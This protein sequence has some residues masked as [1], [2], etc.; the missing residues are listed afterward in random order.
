[1][2]EVKNLVK[3]YS[4]KGGVTVKALDDVSVKFPEKGMVF[5][6]GRSGSGKSTLLNVSGGLDRPDS[7]EIIVK[8]KSSRDFTASDF[9]SYRNTYIGFVFQE[10]N[11]LNEFTVEQNIALALQLQSKPCDRK[12]VEELLKKVDLEGLGKRKPNTLSGG[13]KQRVAIARALIKE[14]EIIMADEPTGALDSST[15]KQVFDTLKKLS[16]T[17]LV[18]VVSH[19]REFAEY[20]GDRIIELKDGKIISDVSKNYAAP[21][22]AGENVELISEDTITVKKAEDITEA[23]IKTIVG[24]LKAQG[25]EAVITANKNELADVKRACRI[26]DD[27]KKEYFAETKEIKTREYGAGDARFI[28]SRLPAS[29]AVK[30][31][32][33]GLK[34]KPVRLLFT[35]F[36]SVIAFTLFGVASTLMLYDSDYSV[37][38][39]LQDAGYPH[40]TINKMYTA[41]ITNYKENNFT[42]ETER[43]S[44]QVRSYGT[45]FGVSELSDKNAGGQGNYAGIFDLS[46]GNSDINTSMRLTIDG[47]NPYVKQSLSRYYCVEN[48]SGFTDCGAQYM[49][50]NGFS[51][52]TD[53]GRYPENATEVA[54]PRYLADLFINTDDNGINSY[55]DLTG[56]KLQVTGNSVLE[57]SGKNEFTVTGVYDVGD[58][59]AKYDALKEADAGNS[60]SETT[61]LATSLRDCLTLSYHTVLYV[62]ED[63]Y[64]VY[65]DGIDVTANSVNIYSKFRTGVMVLPSPIS[66]DFQEGWGINYFSEQTVQRYHDYFDFYDINGNPAEFS[67]NDGEVWLSYE[68]SVN[69]MYDAYN[70]AAAEIMENLSYYSDTGFKDELQSAIEKN[71]YAAKKRI[72]DEYYTVLSE[73]KFVLEYAGHIIAAADGLGM[74]DYGSGSGFAVLYNKANEFIQTTD[75]DKENVMSVAE[76]DTFT[77]KVKTAL[78]EVPAFERLKYAF[79]AIYMYDY[80]TNDVYAGG[81]IANSLNELFD[82]TDFK[83]AAESLLR[84]ENDEYFAIIKSAVNERYEELIY[85]K[86]EFNGDTFKLYINIPKAYYK[87]YQGNSGTLTV[88]GVFKIVSYFSSNYLLPSSFINKHCQF[89]SEEEYS[90]FEQ[91]TTDYTEPSDAK[92]NYLITLTDNS[93]EQISNALFSSLG[94]VKYAVSNSV[95]T[96][97][98]FM[99]E[100]V[101]EL[102]TIFLVMGVVFGIFSG[103]MLFNFIS[104]SITA[105]KKDIGILRAVG[106]RGSDV[107][108][109]FFS[110]AFFIAIICILIAAV[111]GYFVCGT[112]NKSLISIV[113]VDILNYGG[114]N[115]VLMLCIALAV[116]AVATFFPVYFAAKKPPVESIRSL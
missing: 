35:I 19:D 100:T 39:A 36:L 38:Q 17:R 60:S 62:S 42:G 31:G 57:S 101:N 107:F 74:T 111:A 26:N 28:K 69:K 27:G 43:D 67:I 14:P 16:E 15:G 83:F 68:M 106:A 8:G 51:L 104:A 78:T 49:S 96:Q 2:L 61:A 53:G 77:A 112:L 65:K 115:V 73:R 95:Y 113:S 98:S 110:E 34:T 58:I 81:V 63:F 55:G 82:G 79:F 32:A 1:M 64:D 76:W 92:Y 25:G 88:K 18:V 4:T 72:V 54:L 71:N 116:S 105:K 13:Q 46:G 102:K 94:Y 33:S 29:H 44:D 91:S 52:L 30:I 3:C 108:K 99:I 75:G 12:A 7:G 80:G 97:L 41:T 5:L 48:V 90:W 84:E 24:M 47:K 56:K 9:D 85:R 20:Y 50:E 59:P 11:I 23:D 114:V 89:L 22:R 6:L 10:Y 93:Q 45:R 86:P 87:D 40:L 66:E 103:L 109:I 70:A 21:D 37:A